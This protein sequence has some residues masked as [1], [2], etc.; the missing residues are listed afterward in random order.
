MTVLDANLVEI[1]RSNSR[2]R[3]NRTR[4]VEGRA[5]T[6]TDEFL[7]LFIP[8]NGTAKVSAGSGQGN[9][10]A[11]FKSGKEQHAFGDGFD[12]SRYE[13]FRPTRFDPLCTLQLSI[14]RFPRFQDR[15]TEP[16]QLNKS[17]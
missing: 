1:K 13:G 6:R 17:Q 9:E 7:L 4:T 10:A 8:G 12:V 11:V 14:S 5:M 2:G 15:G 16:A 3:Q